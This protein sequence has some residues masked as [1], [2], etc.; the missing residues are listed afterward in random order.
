MDSDTGRR[1][2]LKKLALS[3]AAVTTAGTATATAGTSKN[4][5]MGAVQVPRRTLGK[6]NT[7]VSILALGLGS[8][9][10]KPRAEDPEDT[11]AI[12]QR[13]L[14]H[15]INYWD[16]ANGYGPSQK[17]LGPIVEKNRDKIFLVS[18]SRLH[19]T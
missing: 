14:D 6:T 10:T 18:K 5:A 7:E 1:D 8:V 3:G 17:M 9:F 19:L 15:G 12:L 13:A 11:A 4:K 16:T 2:F